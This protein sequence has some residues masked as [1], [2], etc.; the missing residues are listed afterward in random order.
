MAVATTVVV[1]SVAL[2]NAVSLSSMKKPVVTVCP[3]ET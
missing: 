2:C 1:L 3:T